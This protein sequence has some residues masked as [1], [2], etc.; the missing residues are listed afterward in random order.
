[1]IDEGDCSRRSVRNRMS[2]LGGQ[3]PGQDRRPREE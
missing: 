3:T 1:M 2:V